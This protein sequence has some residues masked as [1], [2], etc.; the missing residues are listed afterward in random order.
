[1]TS[2]SCKSLTSVSVDSLNV[3][4]HSCGLQMM[5]N[6]NLVF[7]RAYTKPTERRD[8]HDSTTGLPSR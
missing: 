3:I 8:V 6:I 1:M 2:I 7:V 5:C 4:A